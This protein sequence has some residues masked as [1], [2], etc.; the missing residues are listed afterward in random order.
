MDLIDIISNRQELGF[1]GGSVRLL[2]IHR[3]VDRDYNSSN[4]YVRHRM[5]IVVEIDDEA[6]DGGEL[7]PRLP[8]QRDYNNGGMRTS[9]VAILL[10]EEEARDFSWGR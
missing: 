6:R 5:T 3:T 4:P 10:S 7:K 8:T 1:T 2:S 9:I